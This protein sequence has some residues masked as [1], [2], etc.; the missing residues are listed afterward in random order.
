[1]KIYIAGPIT[2]NANYEDEFKEAELSLKAQGHTP[3]NPAKLPEGLKYEEYMHICF[4][5]IDISEGLFL[6][7]NWKGS[8]GARREFGYALKNR[9]QI[10][11]G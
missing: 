3:L 1:L 6:L 2:G 7:P 8:P 9:K 4:A 10:Y 5:M 11:K